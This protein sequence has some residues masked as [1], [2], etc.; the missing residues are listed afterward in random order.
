[1]QV[2]ALFKQAYKDYKSICRLVN[3]KD[4]ESGYEAIQKDTKHDAQTMYKDNEL[5][6]VNFGVCCFTIDNIRGKGLVNDCSIEVW[7]GDCGLIGNYTATEI[8]EKGGVQQ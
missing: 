8:M 6:D 2:K 5:Y 1:M 3:N 7:H 4:F